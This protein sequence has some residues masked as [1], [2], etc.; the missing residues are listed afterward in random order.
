MMVYSTKRSWVRPPPP[1]GWISPAL[2][3]H[4]FHHVPILMRPNNNNKHFNAPSLRKP[5]VWREWDGIKAWSVVPGWGQLHIRAL[6]RW[7]QRLRNNNI[8][9]H[10][11]E[12]KFAGCDGRSPLPREMWRFPW[13]V[14]TED[15]FSFFA[16]FLLRKYEGNPTRIAKTD[17]LDFRRLLSDA[18]FLFLFN[19]VLWFC[20]SSLV[21]NYRSLKSI[22]RQATFPFSTSVTEA[23]CRNGH[24]LNH[25]RRKTF[26]TLRPYLSLFNI[27]HGRWNQG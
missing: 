27:R 14:V 1:W 5:H 17:Y 10:S 7:S 11:C 21:P 12:R 15:I 25:L 8:S 2:A 6:P 22:I 4:I 18:P 20:C 13:C 19:F 23:L 24:L 26:T 9:E 3:S 16:N